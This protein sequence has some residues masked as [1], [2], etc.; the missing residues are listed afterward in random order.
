MHLLV[1]HPSIIVHNLKGGFYVGKNVLIWKDKNKLPYFLSWHDI[2]VSYHEE[3]YRR[4]DKWVVWFSGKRCRCIGG[5]L[6]KP[7]GTILFLIQDHSRQ[8]LALKGNKRKQ[9]PKKIIFYLACDADAF[10]LESSQM[11]ISKKR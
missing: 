11:G 1:L 7:L 5:P 9:N 2:L 3:G 6:F 4:Q 10:Y 8:S